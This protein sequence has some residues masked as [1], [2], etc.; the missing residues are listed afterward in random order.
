MHDAFPGLFAIGEEIHFMD[1]AFSLE[2]G[3]AAHEFQK[4][5]YASKLAER[6]P[7][8]DLHRLER[9][10]RRS[11]LIVTARDAG[12]L[13]GVSRA[14]TDFAYCCYVSDLAVDV[15]YQRRGIGKQLI[16]KTHLAAGK[17]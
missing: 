4:L 13:V 8:D 17:D 16:E 9:M 12:R 2:P 6:R 5:L 7:A 3:L 11:D 15:H 14:I 10:L 1:I